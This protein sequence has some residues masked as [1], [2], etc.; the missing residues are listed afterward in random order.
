MVANKRELKLVGLLLGTVVLSN[1]VAEPIQEF[2]TKNSPVS[3]LVLGMVGFG[4]M[5]YFFDFKGG[6]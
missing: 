6:I 3:P 2:I 1:L 5:L 4:L